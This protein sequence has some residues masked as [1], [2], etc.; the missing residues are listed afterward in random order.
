MMNFFAQ[1][2]DF[3]GAYT[4]ISQSQLINYLALRAMPEKQGFSDMYHDVIAEFAS[5]GNQPG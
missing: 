1:I 2:S 5:F 3:A 4:N